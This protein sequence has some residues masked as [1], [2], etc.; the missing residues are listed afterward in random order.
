MANK[1]MKSCSVS[2]VTKEVQMKIT[3][4]YH[5]VH[6]EWLKS[7]TL[8]TPNA[9]EDEEQQ[10]LSLIAGGDAKWYSHF[11]RQFGIFFNKIKHAL[12]M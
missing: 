7:Q 3:M 5:Q 12:S 10:E 6:I 9:G 2:Y 8:R 4:R 11:G 1:H